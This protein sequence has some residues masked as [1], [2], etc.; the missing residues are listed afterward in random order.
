MDFNAAHAL[1]AQKKAESKL[2]GFLYIS[3]RDRLAS[4]PCYNP[5]AGVTAM[6]KQDSINQPREQV[7]ESPTSRRHPV[8]LENSPEETINRMR[9]LPARAEKFRETLR[10][11]RACLELKTDEVK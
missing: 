9:S 2:S 3:R 7:E 5:P 11:L 1:A 4:R 10:A 8:T 6:S